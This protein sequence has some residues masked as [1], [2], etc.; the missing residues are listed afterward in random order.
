MLRR[1]LILFV[2]VGCH[3]AS[4]P[5]TPETWTD[6]EASLPPSTR[7]TPRRFMPLPRPAAPRV[8]L[9]HATILTATGQ[10]IEDGAIVL[11]DGKIEA[12]GRSADVP[13]GQGDLDVRG[14]FVTPGIIDTHSHLGVYSAPETGNANQD[15]NEM[16]NI[17]TPS[18]DAAAG[19]NPQDP[20][21]GRAVAGG[22]TAAQILP[23]SGNLIGGTSVVVEMRLGVSVDDVAFPGAPRGLK[24]A[25][26]ENPKR[27]YAEKGGPMSRMGLYP[28]LRARYE[29]AREYA[30]KLRDYQAQRAA[31]LEKRKHGGKS[32]T[33]PTPVTRDDDL[34]VLAAV[35]RG[36]I[37]VHVHCYRAGEHLEMMSLADDLGFKIRSFHHSLEA[38]KIRDRLAAKQIA[39]STWADWWGFKL[40]A[41]DGI[42]ENAALVHEAGGRAIIHSDSALGIQKLN[43]EAAKA[44]AAG[45]AAGVKL[46]DD[47]VLRWITANPAWALGIDGQTGTLEKGKRAD[48]VVW[49]GHPLSVYARAERVYIAGHEAYRLGARPAS[50]FELGNA[51]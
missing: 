33:A 49:S 4:K 9:R 46:S 22:V 14:K 10:T 18:A 24:M 27:V 7:A 39:V 3:P 23:G 44:M 6:P 20:Q 36:E 38:Y 25:C 31:W 42:P 8:V 1:C 5:T 15:G 50:D 41:W 34:E 37:L 12:I 45:R 26:G 16:T 29:K 40:E 28:A 30:G 13:A 35:L 32:E 47:D 43:Q 21:I 2:L 51:P 17:F 48:V 19:Y 11:A